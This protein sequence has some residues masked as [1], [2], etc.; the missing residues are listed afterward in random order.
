MIHKFTKV[1]VISLVFLFPVLMATV[2]SSVS[3]SYLLILIVGLI[4]YRKIA[5]NPLG[6]S[7]KLVLFGFLGVFAIYLLGMFNSNDI[8]K[9]FKILGKFHYFLF[10]IPVYFILRQYKDI[11]WKNL[12][13]SLII[14]G[15]SLLLFLIVNKG[16][17]GAYH[18]IMYGSFAMLIAG[19]NLLT[20]TLTD[21]NILMKSLLLTSGVAA[22]GA[23]LIVGARGSWVALLILAILLLILFVKRSNTRQRITVL[24]VSS[25]LAI[26]SAITT[27]PTET[28]G[29]Y[30]AAVYHLT[31]FIR[32][33]SAQ[34]KDFQMTSTGAR[35][36]FW[37]SSIET[38][39]NH[40]IFGSGS[41][42]FKLE[43]N[44]F[45][46]NNPKY[47]ALGVGVFGTAHN[48]YFEWLALLGG[49]GFIGL[50]IVV[51]FLPLQYFYREIKN[52]PQ[53]LVPAIIGV[54]LVLSHLIFGLTET[55]IVRSAPNGVY[56]FYILLFMAFCHQPVKTNSRQLSSQ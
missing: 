7:E 29:R 39:N 41:G 30:N 5:K 1:L 34:E 25:T 37:K 53:S 32:D 27:H 3:T 13:I 2:T 9:G 44:Q 17:D 51:F 20:Y 15:F 23:S 36:A 19:A 48:I 10:A 33:E 6:K 52:N 54:W 46:K 12:D 18:S 56:V 42:D 21:K 26:G 4:N 45:I 22:I 16:S 35:L 40:P 11:L 38:F 8:Y 24:I 28:I 31:Q 50:M 14:A 47:K 43:L 49:V 55:W